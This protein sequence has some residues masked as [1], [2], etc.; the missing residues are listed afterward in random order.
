MDRRPHHPPG[1]ASLPSTD[2]TCPELRTADLDQKRGTYSYHRFDD[3]VCGP[4][5]VEGEAF[6]NVQI[7][8]KWKFRESRWGYIDGDRPAGVLYLDIGLHQQADYKLVSV[9]VEVKLED[10]VT[11]EGGD[12]GDRNR[13]GE[14][15]VQMTN[16][17][18]PK[19]MV[20]REH[21]QNFAQE[22]KSQPTSLESPGIGIGDMGKSQSGS[23][24]RSRRDY[25]GRLKRPNRSKTRSA[26]GTH[27]KTL[28]WTM[29]ENEL[30][31]ARDN[32]IHVAFTFEH[33]GQPFHMYA[34]VEGTLRSKGDRLLSGPR[35]LRFGPRRGRPGD[36]STTYVGTYSGYR[37]P[38]DELAKS[39]DVAMQERNWRSGPAEVSAPQQ[40]GFEDMLSP[41]PASSSTELPAVEQ[42]QEAGD[43]AQQARPALPIAAQPRRELTSTPTPTL[44]NPFQHVV[45]TSGSGR[46]DVLERL[47]MAGRRFAAA[48]TAEE[49]PDDRPGIPS[50]FAAPGASDTAGLAPSEL[51]PLSP[52]PAASVVSRMSSVTLV[53]H[54][55][56]A[57]AIGRLPRVHNRISSPPAPMLSPK[58]RSSPFGMLRAWLVAMIRLYLFFV[59]GIPLRFLRLGIAIVATAVRLVGAIERRISQVLAKHARI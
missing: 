5:S 2:R 15:P 40:P 32:T 45:S 58:E 13:H 20:G 52:P 50:M 17:F 3:R 36:L 51:S 23:P 56:Q 48:S 19:Q 30:E 46:Q 42:E 8:L 34:K 28:Q 18:G 11:D 12:D 22:F 7:D 38:L 1:S 57:A 43:P 16:W 54:A 14:I 41:P 55:E 31:L 49:V 25:A 53:D 4:A 47:A 44:P 21:V 37:M 33:G 24:L 6:G 27:Y 59:V 35:D 29:S 10:I 9:T 26:D 39:L